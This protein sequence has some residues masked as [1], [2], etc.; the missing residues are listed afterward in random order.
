MVLSLRER[1]LRAFPY[2]FVSIDFFPVRCYNE[3]IPPKGSFPSMNH[4]PTPPG[5]TH[6]Y[7]R[8]LHV[9]VAILLAILIVANMAL[10][11][12]FSAENGEESGNRSE[13]VTDIVIDVTY[14]DFNELP[15]TEQESLLAHVHH[16]VR[17][18]AHFLEYALL[19]LLTACLLLHLRRRLIPR[20]RPWQTRVFP[21]GFCLAYAV[22]DE[23]HQIFSNRGPRV[24]DV[25]IDFAGAVCGV[26]AVHVAVWVIRCIR[27]AHQRKTGKE[28]DRV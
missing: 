12:F 25:L 6:V 10:I 27:T 2:F 11:Y 28:A 26:C 7:N 24:T 3:G 14:P 21:A 1:D 5:E 15:A 18:T 13:G 23:I 20:I 22:T 16:L 8:R 19:G 4:H 17:K 9:T